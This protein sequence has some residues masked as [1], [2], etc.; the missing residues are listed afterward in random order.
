MTISFG[1]RGGALDYFTHTNGP[2]ASD[3][4]DPWDDDT[5]LQRP[6]YLKITD[7]LGAQAVD[8]IDGFAKSG[9]PFLVSV[10][11]NAPHWPWEAP[12]DEAE[13]QRLGS[14]WHF[15]GGTQRT[16]QQMIR[17]MDLQIGRVLQALDANGAASN[18]IVRARRTME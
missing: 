8:V 17:Q 16:Y 13:A 14:L 2:P 9:R 7:L 3:T 1:F 5:K 15:D 18:T 4:E 12:G 11:F 6:G 10:H